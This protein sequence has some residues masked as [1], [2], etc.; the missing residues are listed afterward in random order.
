[1]TGMSDSYSYSK[2]NEHQLELIKKTLIQQ[3][4]P[5]LIVLFG[6]AAAGKLRN[7]SDIDIAFLSDQPFDAYQIFMIAQQLASK[8]NFDVDLINLNE[9]STVFKSQIV[10]HGVILYDSEPTRRMYYYMNALKAYAMLNE[11]RQPI[12]DKIKERG[13]AYDK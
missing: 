1:M 13:A 10:G 11:E 2:L 12:L 5:H 8:L 7:D 6:S 9:A 3:L 4:N